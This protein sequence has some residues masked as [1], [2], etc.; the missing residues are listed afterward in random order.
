MKKRVVVSAV[1]SLSGSYIPY[2]LHE[3][4]DDN[5]Q[6]ASAVVGSSSMPFIFPPKNMSEFGQDELLIDGGSVWNNNLLS[7]I[8]QCH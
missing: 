4:G 2:S 1:D 3:M 8:E 6:K 7:G 5:A